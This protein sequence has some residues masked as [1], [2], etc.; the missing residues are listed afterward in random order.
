LVAKDRQFYDPYLVL[1]KY[2]G[3]QVP[4]TEDALKG[5]FRA[6]VK[7]LHTDVSGGDTKSQFVEMKAAYD[8]LV[9]AKICSRNENGAIP[10]GLTTD[11]TLLSE[12][13]L[14]LGPTKNGRDCTQCNHRGYQVRLV[15]DSVVCPSC[16]GATRKTNSRRFWGLSCLTCYDTGRISTATQKTTYERCYHCKGTGEIEIWNPVLPKGSLR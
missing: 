9:A 1:E 2:F 7:K 14:G 13:G 12:L 4:V 5:A 3:L 11:G 16:K 10:E 15:Y 6:Q 8:Y